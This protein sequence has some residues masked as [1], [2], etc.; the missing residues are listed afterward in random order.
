MA[1]GDKQEKQFYDR[2]ADS[3]QG[4]I[5]ENLAARFG[6]TTS[7][8]ATYIEKT[9]DG[10]ISATSVRTYAPHTAAGI[11][12]AAGIIAMPMLQKAG[13]AVTGFA[14]NIVTGFGHLE[15]IPVIGKA[16][17][18]AGWLI[19]RVGDVSG[20]LLT[21]AASIVS[22]NL[23]RAKASPSVGDPH[24]T[25]NSGTGAE[26]REPLK[27]D[28]TL[29]HPTTKETLLVLKGAPV[30]LPPVTLPPQAQKLL[31]EK[32]G[33]AATDY[34]KLARLRAD[35]IKAQKLDLAEMLRA[36]QQGANQRYEDQRVLL[37][38]ISEF[39]SP[40]P[41]SKRSKAVATLSTN[42]LTRDEA[43][44]LM[45][46][47]S[48]L[49]STV[50]PGSA[51]NMNSTANNMLTDFGGDA[52]QLL[53]LGARFETMYGKKYFEVSQ[54]DAMG[55]K[56]D[57]RKNFDEMS[58]T[59]KHEFLEKALEH[60]RK[61]YRELSK[62]VREEHMLTS[63]GYTH[64]SVSSKV[65]YNFDKIPPRTYHNENGAP[66]REVSPMEE[67]QFLSGMNGDIVVS[68]NFNAGGYHSSGTTLKTGNGLSGSTGAFEKWATLLN[69]HKAEL[70]RN[71]QAYAGEIKRYL[72]RF[73][74]AEQSTEMNHKH[75]IAL[76][77]YSETHVQIRDLRKYQ[78][79]VPP[80]PEQLNRWEG[81]WAD[82]AR[83]TF[84]VRSVT[85]KEGKQTPLKSAVT[86]NFSTGE[87]MDKLLDQMD[88]A[89]TVNA[90]AQTVTIIGLDRFS[91]A[92]RATI[93]DNR[94]SG[95]PAARQYAGRF[96][97]NRFIA[98]G[99]VLPGKTAYPTIPA[100][101]LLPLRTKD[102]YEPAGKKTV[103]SSYASGG[104]QF[105]DVTLKGPD[106]TVRT[107]VVQT[108][109]GRTVRNVL[110]VALKDEGHDR[111]DLAW[112]E[113]EY[114]TFA[115][116]HTKIE[117]QGAI[118]NNDEGYIGAAKYAA[119]LMD[120]PAIQRENENRRKMFEAN[121]TPADRQFIAPLPQPEIVIADVNNPN[122]W[123]PLLDAARFTVGTPQPKS[124]HPLDP[125]KSSTHMMEITDK[126]F[127][128][129]GQ[130]FVHGKYDD[131]TKTFTAE[132]YELHPATIGPSTPGTYVPLPATLDL[133]K[134]D[135]S[136]LFAKITSNYHKKELESLPQ[137]A[138]PV[139]G[140]PGK[141]TLASAKEIPEYSAT[142]ITVNDN[143]SA[144]NP[145][146]LTLIFYRTGD[147][148]NQLSDWANWGGDD[149]R[150][151]I[152]NIK[153]SEPAKPVTFTDEEMKQIREGK[154]SLDTVIDQQDTFAKNNI[155]VKLIKSENG[156]R[157]IRITDNRNPAAPAEYDFMG[158]VD[159]NDFIVESG[160]HKG[161]PI[162]KG[163][164]VTNMSSTKSWLE[165]LDTAKQAAKAPAAQAH[166]PKTTPGFSGAI[167]AQ[168]GS[169]P[170][171]AL[172]SGN[173]TTLPTNSQAT[174]ALEGDQGKKATVP[175]NPK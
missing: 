151:L 40:A 9:T 80:A 59:Q 162:L 156:K 37:V 113:A 36:L 68:N 55:N 117:F 172:T 66:G 167:D 125:F 24:K 57:V 73:R 129:Y 175:G 164:T 144:P 121:L 23:F 115:L 130:V 34:E 90:P 101:Q 47:P 124:A 94:T 7:D 103:S 109:P 49:R 135:F 26:G 165:L 96:D 104:D 29:R 140:T 84:T 1:E 133:A 161:V 99:I 171:L 155:A 173:V 32:P 15:K 25:P 18:G 85:N 107:Y 82:A 122:A 20:Y 67:Y 51:P 69:E 98:T 170:H 93:A 56:V 39:A 75:A 2:W 145:Q 154:K 139:P 141:L 62:H 169:I 174:P 27:H 159:K 50:T 19:D 97:G 83:N 106:G 74:F 14:R 91:K 136:D 4:W 87:G 53:S 30:G 41:D 31:N 147:N 8:A 10:K 108:E 61:Q 44:K 64:A 22:F 81:E 33:L 149:V 114:R 46:L 160:A 45:P 102:D 148:T 120:N 110:S 134:R 88:K 3:A 118:R 16:F 127:K 143:R 5:N 21:G 6:Q 86:V 142:V 152:D 112:W 77:D 12:A 150:E 42:G 131:A 128:F 119:T 126:N 166:A 78:P 157:Y 168:L 38:R 52:A 105:T 92:P 132:G 100:D 111:A 71:E 123:T 60:A 35:A 72:D 48:D 58:A 158:T 65:V 43:Q 17:S 28:L 138:L 70:K 116:P 146:T 79:N 163:I 76:L 54:M 89:R 95:D 153:G 11:T 63:A 137:T 13:K